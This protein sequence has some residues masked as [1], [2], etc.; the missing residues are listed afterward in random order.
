MT[1]TALMKLRRFA[2]LTVIIG[3]LHCGAIITSELIMFKNGSDLDHPEIE[4]SRLQQ[5]FAAV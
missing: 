5:V 4:P 2:I 3:L 1:Y